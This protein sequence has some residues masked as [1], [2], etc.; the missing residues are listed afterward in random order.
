M[1]REQSMVYSQLFSQLISSDDTMEDTMASFL[2]YL[3]PRE[4]FVRALSLLD[5]SDMFIYILD[6]A[7]GVSNPMKKQLTLTDADNSI[8]RTTQSAENITMSTNDPS[9]ST[10]AGSLKNTSSKDNNLSLESIIDLLYNAD[11]DTE[12]LSR[13]IVKS[14]D[15]SS[16]PASVDLSTWFCSCDE[17]SELF[18]ETHQQLKET[19]LIDALIT[20]QD[21]FQDFSDDKFAQIDAHSLSKQRYAQ[22]SKLMCPHLLA[23]SIILSSSPKT[24]RYFT[25]AKPSVLLITVNSM[26]EWLRLH[27]NIVS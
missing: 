7:S 10:V 6:K 11:S 20:E 12:L 5:S 3:F 17:Y 16:P 23:Y 9:G 4:L 22:H 18:Q 24:L 25:I 27:I 26:D 2:Y 14:N 1:N 8:V 13:L 19:S 21:D 15:E